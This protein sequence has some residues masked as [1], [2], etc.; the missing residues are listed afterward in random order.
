V[1]GGFGGNQVLP[2]LTNGNANFVQG[3][4][5]IGDALS[6]D[7][8]PLGNVVV[9]F[10]NPVDTITIR[11]GNHTTA[12]TNPGQQGISLHDLFVCNPFATLSITKVSSLISDPVNLANNP[13]AIPGALVEYLISVANNGTDATDANSVVVVD[14]GPA[15]A[16]LCQISRA[17]GPVVFADPGGSGLTYSF[18]SLASVGDS[19]EFSNDAGVNWTHVP[20]ADAQGCDPSVTSFRVRPDGGLGA[21]RSFTL[22]VRYIIE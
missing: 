18:A 9:T 7:N 2:Q 16:K 1:V 14:N 6:G 8:E 20:T 11:Y 13:K 4:I 15:D 22:R 12:P 21:G 19:L 10:N 3:N 5:A 17:G